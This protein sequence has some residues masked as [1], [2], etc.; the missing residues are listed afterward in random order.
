MTKLIFLNAKIN[1]VIKADE[2]KSEYQNVTDVKIKKI[3]ISI[4]LIIDNEEN[5]WENNIIDDN[6]E[7]WARKIDMRRRYVSSI[8]I[9]IALF[10]EL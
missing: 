8:F 9:D 6:E 5:E 10:V 1:K 7:K 4:N 2:I 3:I